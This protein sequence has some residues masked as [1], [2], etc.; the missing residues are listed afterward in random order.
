V[1]FIALVLLLAF[2]TLTI[3]LM[4]LMRP[5][6]LTLSLLVLSVL[7]V[8]TLIAQATFAPRVGAIAALGLV[9]LFTA[10]GLA[11][12]SAPWRSD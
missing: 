10:F 2:W 3:A 11:Q 9:I 5:I 12:R 4:V 1:T 7:L 8:G 6:A